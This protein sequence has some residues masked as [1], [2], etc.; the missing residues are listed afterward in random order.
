[1]ALDL[2]GLFLGSGYARFL[3]IEK[4]WPGVLECLV[5]IK[6]RV[7][8]FCLTKMLLESIVFSE[9]PL[10]ALTQGDSPEGITVT[11]SSG[12][13]LMITTKPDWDSIFLVNLDQRI[14]HWADKTRG[15]RPMKPMSRN[16]RKEGPP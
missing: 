10:A 6:E 4:Q 1:M 15:F 2:S 13:R 14:V 5:D 3:L 11:E 12:T 7:K 9:P 16:L 8:T